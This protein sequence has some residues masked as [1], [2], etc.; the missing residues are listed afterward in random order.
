MAEQTLV[1]PTPDRSA[2]VAADQLSRARPARRRRTSRSRWALRLVALGYVG[3][4]VA[5]PVGLVLLRTLDQGAAAFVEAISGPQAVAA[6]RLTAIVAG[7]AVVINTAFGVGA[8]VLLARYRFRGR[9]LL[10]LAI[11]L[12]ISVSPIIVGLALVLAFGWTTGWFGPALH[13]AGLQVIFATPGMVLATAFVSLPLVV[14]EVLPV[15][16][17]TGLEQDQAARSLGANAVQRFRRVTLP[18]IRWALA[19]GVVLSIART[20]GEF[21]AVRV[22][23]G[24]VGSQTQTVTLLVDERAEQFEPGAYQLSVVL[25]AVAAL[26]IVIISIIR[27]HERN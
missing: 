21:G 16:T 10:D 12:P 25:I 1:I 6:F 3:V 5:L 11:D 23:S 18:T 14:R 2:P 15:L 8:A 20:L 24:N 13:N 27:P 19:Y 4:L 9:V 22:V 7:S 26:C 17:E